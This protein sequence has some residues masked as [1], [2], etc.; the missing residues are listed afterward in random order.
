M[1]SEK[2][3]AAENDALEKKIA[4]IEQEVATVKVVIR[5]ASRTRLAMLLAVLLIIGAAIWSF[6]NLAKD[7]TSRENMNLLAD[8]ARVR[9]ESTS[10]EAVKHAKALAETS[11]PVLREAFT[12]QVN[13][14]RAKYQ[15]ALDKEREV[16]SKNLQTALEKKLR[17]HL[18]ESSSK[19]QEILRDEFPDLQD[20]KLMEQMYAN[21]ANM[22][23]R[24]VEEYYSAEIRGQIEGMNDKWLKF[25]LAELPKEGE[26]T[27]EMQFVASLFYLAAMK[28]DEKSIE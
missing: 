11:L 9:A 16:L 25:D 28:I 22:M 17:A 26:P 18:D 23:D 19:Y 8:T 1:T 24:L 15:D 6:Y 10:Q 5:R 4:A 7:F 2:N 14:D 3:P 13:K 20:P 27:L 21:V 12:A